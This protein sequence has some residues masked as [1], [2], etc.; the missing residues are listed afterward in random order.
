MTGCLAAADLL[1]GVEVAGDFVGADR[2]V[3][4]VVDV[5]ALGLEAADV[6]FFA[7]V[8]DAFVDVPPIFTPSSLFS[9]A[10]TI[11]SLERRLSER[12]SICL[13]CVSMRETN[14][15]ISIDDKRKAK[16][17]K[18]SSCLIYVWRLRKTEGLKI[19]T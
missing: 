11:S 12:V 2:G 1:T 4:G 5:E 16:A 19:K 3:F 18:Y 10:S 13:D 14:L 7:G 6:V 8:A 17:L 15:L 9:S